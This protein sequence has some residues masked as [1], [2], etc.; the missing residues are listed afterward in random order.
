MPFPVSHRI[1]IKEGASTNVSWIAFAKVCLLRALPE[2]V[3]SSECRD[4]TGCAD[5]CTGE[6]QDSLTTEESL[7]SLSRSLNWWTALVI[8]RVIDATQSTLDFIGHDLVHLLD[9]IFE[10]SNSLIDIVQAVHVFLPLCLSC[11]N[12]GINVVWGFNLSRSSSSILWYLWIQVVTICVLSSGNFA[13]FLLA[14]S[15]RTIGNGLADWFV[16][17]LDHLYCVSVSSLF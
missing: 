6:N 3:V 12:P 14:I 8:I 2:A 16:S 11:C 9:L 4:T 1:S 10:S 5:P 13:F 7:S 15:F 17:L